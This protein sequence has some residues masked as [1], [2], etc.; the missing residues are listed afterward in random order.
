MNEFSKPSDQRRFFHLNFVLQFCFGFRASHF[1]FLP[2]LLIL[3]FAVAIPGCGDSGPPKYKVTG[4]VTWEGSPLPE[5]DIIL[6]PSNGGIP[7]HGKISA[8]R[9]EMQATEG[10]K[11]VSIMATRAAADVDPEMGAAPQ[12]QY[13]PHRYNANSELTATVQPNDTNQLQF[14]LTEK[15]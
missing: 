2:L 15:P 10:A 9:F 3:G 5:G 7:D 11:T 8:G 14:D 13:I 1:G 4:N 6:T 12:Q